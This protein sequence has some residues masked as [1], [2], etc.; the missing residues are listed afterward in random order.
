VQ[1]ICSPTRSA[2]MTGR[3]TIRLGT[4]ASVIYWDT[5]WGIPI[6]ETFLPQNLK[7][8]G[9]TTAMFGKWHLGMFQRRYT[10]S[11]R[12][13]D[14][15]MGYFQGCGSA[16]THISACCTA[17]SPD[18]D[19]DFVCDDTSQYGAYRGYD[20]FKTGPMP[21]NGIS[22]PDLTANLTNSVHLINAAALDFLGRMEHSSHPWFLYLPF[23][24]IHSPYTAD[25]QFRGMYEKDP[26]RFSDGEMTMFGYITELDDAVGSIIRK[27]QSTNAEDNTIIIF[28]SDNGA[29][30]AS[31]DVNH[32]VNKPDGAGYIA[33][34]HPFR[35]WKTQIWEGGTRVSGFVSSPLLPAAVRG[36]ISNE[37]FHVTDWLPTIARI[38][39]VATTRNFQ[40]DGHDIWDSLTT[41]SPSPR[42]EMLYNINP[43]CTV[44]QA[45]PPKAGIR[46]GKF[47][48]LSWCYNIAGVGNAT[49]TGPVSGQGEF[50]N[51]PLLF[52]LEADPSETTNIASSHPD[53]VKLML[54]RLKVYADNSAEPMTWTPPFQGQGYFCKDC[55]LHPHGAGINGPAVPWDAWC[56]NGACPTDTSPAAADLPRH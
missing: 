32:K 53:Q 50:S 52:D 26:A 39:G 8:A 25:P 30:P 54:A 10:P 16:Y 13:F 48:L 11:H 35:G 49:Q 17:G 22:K 21:N 34:N 20:W 31:D 18:H 23:Q 46:V 40:L 42:T 12:G 36:T 38:A 33:R 6:N 9:Y 29:P 41:G 24:N 3:Y 19:Q 47:K 15:H 51:G 2:L 5:P 45:S 44:G 4:Q 56:D 43:L 27:L 1:P 55:P 7:G 37:L 28:S 14:E